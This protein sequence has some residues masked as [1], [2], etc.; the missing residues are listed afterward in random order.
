[1]SAVYPCEQ[2]ER[3]INSPH[4]DWILASRIAENCPD[5]RIELGETA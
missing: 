4:T 2:H 1:M 3:S 5:C